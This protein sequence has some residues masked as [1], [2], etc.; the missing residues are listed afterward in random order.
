[1]ERLEA[2]ETKRQPERAEKHRGEDIRK[3]MRAQGDSSEANQNNHR[4]R[5]EDAHLS[6][7]PGFHERQNEK[8]KLAIEQGGSDR[9]PAGKTVTRPIDKRARRKGALPLHEKLDQLVE[10][11]PAGN[12]DNETGERWPPS[13]PNEKCSPEKQSDADEFTGARFAQSAQYRHE[14]RRQV[15]MKPGRETL[16]GSG[17][18]IDQG[19]G[20]GEM[21]ERERRHKKGSCRLFI[22]QRRSRGGMHFFK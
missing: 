14:K 3:I 19:E 16:I 18:R 22:L 6:P 2:E 13:F 10:Q 15:E 11:H 21:G 9:V 7:G 17:E 4:D 12:G 5:G 20:C 1:M 8:K